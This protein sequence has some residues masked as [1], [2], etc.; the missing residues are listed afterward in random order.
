MAVKI[1]KD[2]EY[3]KQLYRKAL[4]DFGRDGIYY[5]T[6][7]EEIATRDG[8]CQAW[9]KRRLKYDLSCERFDE[10]EETVKILTEYFG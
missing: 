1:C 9:R 2:C 7:H 3:Y 5:C 10:A 6:V 4:Y 8:T